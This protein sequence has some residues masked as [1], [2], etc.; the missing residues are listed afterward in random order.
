MWREILSR[1]QDKG[2][3]F[4]WVMSFSYKHRAALKVSRKKASIDYPDLECIIY[5]LDLD[6]KFNS[7]FFLS[8]N[9]FIGAKIMNCILM[10][11]Y[12]L[13]RY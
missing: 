4:F 12:I 11:L 8:V 5:E 1:Y 7:D 3:R 9:I 13:W 10:F 2:L 6:S